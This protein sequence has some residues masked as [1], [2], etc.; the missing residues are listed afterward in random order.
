MYRH[1][2]SQM[3]GLVYVPNWCEK[4]FQIKSCIPK[5]KPVFQLVDDLDDDRKGQ[6]YEEEL[7]PIEENRYIIERII[8]KRKTP[9]E[10]RNS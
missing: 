3:K 6:F 1:V 9:Q 10:P 4:H 2:E 8:R 7:Q 5:R